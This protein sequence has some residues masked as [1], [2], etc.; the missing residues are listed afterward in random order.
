MTTAG[1]VFGVPLAM[2]GAG[3]VLTFV[4][5]MLARAFGWREHDSPG[6]EFLLMLGTWMVALGLV[7][8]LA[9]GALTYAV[10]VVVWAREVWQ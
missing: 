2:V 6:A 4:V 7:L 5:A 1:V 10:S 3:V 9:A 8:T